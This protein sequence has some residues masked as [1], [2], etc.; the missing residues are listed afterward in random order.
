MCIY[1]DYLFLSELNKKFQH[2]CW[3]FDQKLLFFPFEWCG[4]AESWMSDGFFVKLW[5]KA[6]ESADYKHESNVLKTPRLMR[7]SSAD[8]CASSVSAASLPSIDE[9]RRWVAD[10]SAGLQADGGR[11]SCLIDLWSSTAP[12]CILS[13]VFLDSTEPSVSAAT[14]RLFLHFLIRAVPGPRVWTQRKQTGKVFADST[15]LTPLSS[16]A[17]VLSPPLTR[18]ENRSCG[19]S[20]PITD[21]SLITVSASGL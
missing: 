3:D 19:G 12:Q 11:R 16:W 9:S 7:L 21:G 10:A 4:M 17:L 18:L 8:L 15:A 1:F 2:P 6:A 14:S 5:V 20:E 13:W